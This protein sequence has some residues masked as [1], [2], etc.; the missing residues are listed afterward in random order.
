MLDRVIEHNR[1]LLPTILLVDKFPKH[2]LD[3]CFARPTLGD[4]DTIELLQERRTQAN[5][6]HRMRA[7]LLF[8]NLSVGESIRKVLG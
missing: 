4:R 8:D 2:A 1:K 3:K 6:S 5:Q 7:W